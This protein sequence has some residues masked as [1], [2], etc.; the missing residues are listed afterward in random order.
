MLSFSILAT[1]YS[2][3]HSHHAKKGGAVHQ[4][5]N[6]KLTDLELNFTWA[7]FEA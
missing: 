1:R 5:M 3:P 2:H 4:S 7:L 6:S